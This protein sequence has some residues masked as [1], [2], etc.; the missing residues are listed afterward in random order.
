MSLEIVETDVR[1]VIITIIGL[2]LVFLVWDQTTNANDHRNLFVDRLRDLCSNIVFIL[3]IFFTLI[4]MRVNG[5]NPKI[6]IIIALMIFVGSGFCVGYY[7]QN[8]LYGQF[9]PTRRLFHL[10]TVAMLYFIMFIGFVLFQNKRD[11]NFNH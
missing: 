11:D 9:K 10:K 3:T 8:F 5:T 6:P 4:V 2:T 7:Y 1:Y